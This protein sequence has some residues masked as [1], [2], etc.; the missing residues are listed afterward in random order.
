MVSPSRRARSTCRSRAASSA[1]SIAR[2]STN[3]C[4]NV[5]PLRARCAAIGAFERID[6]DA[7]GTAVVHYRP[8]GGEGEHARVRARVSHRRRRRRSHVARQSGAWRRARCRTSSP[9][10]RSSRSPQAASRYDST[11]RAATSY[12]R[13]ALSPDFYAWVFPARRR[14]RASARAAPHKGFSLRD[15]VGDAARRRPASTA[16]RRSAAKARRS[17]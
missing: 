16:A 10:T 1:W 17:R 7:D 8:N 12:Y 2:C 4:G 13:G 6:R 3:G 15:A 11:A 5:R 14:P 9:T